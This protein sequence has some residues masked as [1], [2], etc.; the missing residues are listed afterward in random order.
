MSRS[1]KRLILSALTAV[2]AAASL[3]VVT[4]PQAS[5]INRVECNG[6]TDFL[7]IGAHPSGSTTGSTFC[8]ANAGESTFQPWWDD[9]A[10]VTWLS[11]GN[12]RVQYHADGNWQPG[13]PINKWTYYVWDHHP[14]GVK[15]DRIRI[16]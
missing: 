15:V 8:Y 11:T 14:G 16:H 13:T 3:T 7:Q 6:R 12:N 1:A 4:A 2:M 5:A 9:Y 10:W